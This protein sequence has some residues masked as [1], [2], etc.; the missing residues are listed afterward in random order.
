MPGAPLNAQPL[1]TFSLKCQE[2]LPQSLRKNVEALKKKSNRKIQIAQQDSRCQSVKDPNLFNVG[3][4]VIC[5][6][7]FVFQQSA[8]VPILPPGTNGKSGAT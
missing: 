7:S 8:G 6:I 1:V 4:V 5:S 3:T 2:E